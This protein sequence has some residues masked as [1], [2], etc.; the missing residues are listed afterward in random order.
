MTEHRAIAVELNNAVWS[1]LDADGVTEESPVEDRERLLYAAYASTWHWMQVGTPANHAR[2]EHLISRVAA[3]V[4][5]PDLALHHARRCLAIVDD[6]PEACEDWDRAFALEALARALAA[7]GDTTAAA[8]MLER[9]RGAT[10]AVADPEDR[11]I[12][13][14]ELARPPWFGLDG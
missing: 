6:N 2:G 1:S 14:R 12:V 5:Y 10:E 13:E 7:T 11:V 9:A 4:G 8:E 3:R